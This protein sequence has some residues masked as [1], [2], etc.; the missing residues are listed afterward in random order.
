MVTRTYVD[1]FQTKVEQSYVNLTKLNSSTYPAITSVRYEYTDSSST[2]P[3]V[4]AYYIY[5]QYALRVL[6]ASV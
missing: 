4:T 2:V 5:D 1:S 6:T 3:A